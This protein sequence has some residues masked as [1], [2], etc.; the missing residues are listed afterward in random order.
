M[1]A[2]STL[3]VGVACSCRGSNGEPGG[4]LSRTQVHDENAALHTAQ[5]H[6]SADAG[7]TMSSDA[8]GSDVPNVRVRL[9]DDGCV[10]K[11]VWVKPEVVHEYA[12]RVPAGFVGIVRA[13]SATIG[14]ASLPASLTVK[15]G[16]YA[17]FDDSDRRCLS[18][19]FAGRVAA[20]L[21]VS[22]LRSREKWSKYYK[23]R[24]SESGSSTR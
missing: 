10:V 2:L 8:G 15:K 20:S 24:R 7:I 23:W 9:Y 12:G 11:H 14:F 6:G 3:I 1:F 22:R 17:E 18:V 16:L 5:A 4:H 13:D 21:C 19:V